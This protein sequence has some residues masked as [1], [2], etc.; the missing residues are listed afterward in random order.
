[1]E[2]TLGP[3]GPPHEFSRRPSAAVRRRSQEVRGSPLQE[4]EEGLARA[5]QRVGPPQERAVPGEPHVDLPPVAV[6]G[7]GVDVRAHLGAA[8]D[9][10][11]R[12]H[13]RKCEAVLREGS[14]A[15]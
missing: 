10:L 8:L 5:H 7:E 14:S 3:H 4:V 15:A 11:A 12:A 13:A 9:E 2:S 1:M 6:A